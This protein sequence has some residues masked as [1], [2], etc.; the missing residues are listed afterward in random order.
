MSDLT[1]PPPQPGAE[2]V[3]SAVI[4]W[5]AERRERGIAKYGT[6]LQTFNGRDPVAD[7]MEEHLD[8]LQYLMQWRL[9]RRALMA[10]VEQ[11]RGALGAM[12]EAWDRLAASELVEPDFDPVM[13]AREAMNGSHS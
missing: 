7:A 5:L 10:E 2:D 6:T 4:A 13:R 12:V 3:T 8:A 1:Q 11:L 9:E